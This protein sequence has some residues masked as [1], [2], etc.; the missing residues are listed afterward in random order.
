V[1]GHQDA[2]GLL[3]HRHSVQWRSTERRN[4]SLHSVHYGAP[5]GSQSPFWESPRRR[6]HP[7][8]AGST[9]GRY[10]KFASRGADV[11]RLRR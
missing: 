9:T 8:P 11:S 6:S 5:K 10:T 2:L 7:N 3:D 4:S 1:L